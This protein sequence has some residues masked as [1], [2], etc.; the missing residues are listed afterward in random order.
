MSDHVVTNG[1]ELTEI[2]SKCQAPEAAQ[3][4]HREVLG[5]IRYTIQCIAIDVKK[6]HEL[7]D[8]EPNELEKT[9]HK[10][11]YF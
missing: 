6:V 9:E 11:L 4:N 3:H 10:F 8:D 7:F 2:Q 1:D 5:R